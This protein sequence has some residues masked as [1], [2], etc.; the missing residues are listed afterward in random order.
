MD[1]FLSRERIK[2]ADSRAEAREKW[3]WEAHGKRAK[4]NR[5]STGGRRVKS[6]AESPKPHPARLI[7]T[8]SRGSGAELAAALKGLTPNERAVYEGRLLADTQVSLGELAAQLGVTR[9]RIVALEKQARQRMERL[10][11]Q[12]N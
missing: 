8:H 11:K 5:T 1:N 9:P 2:T 7:A 4:G 3:K 10:L 6:F 12:G